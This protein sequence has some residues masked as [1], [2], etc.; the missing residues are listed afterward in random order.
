MLYLL[1]FTTHFPP[2]VV[3]RDWL[4]TLSMFLRFIHVVACVSDSFLIMWP[5]NI[6]LYCYITSC[7]SIHQLMGIWVIYNFGYYIMLLWTFLYKFLFSFLLGT[8]PRVELSGHKV[9]SWLTFWGTAKLFGKTA[10]LFYI[11]ISNI[12]G[13]QCPYILTNTCDLSLL[14]WLS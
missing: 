11:L 14:L 2:R 6:P 13:V 8:H 5:H 7:L 9:T 1:A 12:R 4:L 3:F 10:A